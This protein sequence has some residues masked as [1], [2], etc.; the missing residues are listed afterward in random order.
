MTYAA[1]FVQ[2]FKVHEMVKRGWFD[3]C[4]LI[5]V[6]VSVVDIVTVRHHHLNPYPRPAHM[7]VDCNVPLH[8]DYILSAG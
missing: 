8:H 1:M 4:N 2:Y 5:E 6:N 7:I 3:G